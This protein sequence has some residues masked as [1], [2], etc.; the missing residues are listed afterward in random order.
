MTKNFIVLPRLIGSFSGS[1]LYWN[2][3]WQFQQLWHKKSAK[4][5]KLKIEVNLNASGLLRDQTCYTLSEHDFKKLIWWS[6]GW[7]RFDFFHSI[8]YFMNRIE[9]T[10][11][12]FQL[13]D[14]D[15]SFIDQATKNE[16]K[17]SLVK[18]F[19]LEAILWIDP[20][21]TF[22]FSYKWEMNFTDTL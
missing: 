3:E 15:N 8:G 22:L 18:M 7:K 5:E 17:E 16:T 14:D 19:L 1:W 13:T 12:D 10:S 6:P 21:K 11:S 20:M 4:I 2:R 9:K